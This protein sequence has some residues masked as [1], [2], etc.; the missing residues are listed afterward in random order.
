MLEWWIEITDLW[1]LTPE[2]CTGSLLCL[3]FPTGGF[4]R[5]I[6]ISILVCVWL[7]RLTSQSRQHDDLTLF[8]VRDETS[9]A[10]IGWF[11]CRNENGTWRSDQEVLST[12]ICLLLIKAAPTE[13]SFRRWSIKAAARWLAVF[14]E[15]SGAGCQITRL[16][17]FVEQTWSS[18]AT[19]A[20]AKL[21]V[22]S[23]FA[24]N[25]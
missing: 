14:D 2:S 7:Q 10:R 21:T 5:I 9:S 17:W 1:C 3:P 19:V 13:E 16:I 23:I 4:P 12:G 25:P 8:D 15:R 20:T 24:W 11:S 18:W 22:V 6:P